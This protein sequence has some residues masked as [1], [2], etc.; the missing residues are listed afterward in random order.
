MRRGGVSVK[1]IVI[2]WEEW[3]AGR[4]AK[5]EQLRKAGLDKSSRRERSSSDKRLKKAFGGRRAP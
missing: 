2:S 1:E 3:Q 5:R 4:K